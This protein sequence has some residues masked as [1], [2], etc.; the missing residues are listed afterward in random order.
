MSEHSQH[1]MK[2]RLATPPAAP[3]SSCF[4]CYREGTPSPDQRVVRSN[5]SRSLASIRFHC[6]HCDHYWTTDAHEARQHGAFLRRIDHNRNAD[7]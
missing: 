3:A 1:P 4:R 6:T 5:G 2:K 7:A